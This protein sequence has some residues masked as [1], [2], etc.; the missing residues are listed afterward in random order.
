LLEAEAGGHGASIYVTRYVEPFCAA[1][2]MIVDFL[3]ST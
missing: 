1:C 2:V 3:L